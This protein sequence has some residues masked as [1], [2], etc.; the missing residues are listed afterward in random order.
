MLRLI[1]LALALATLAGCPEETAPTPPPAATP[2]PPP[3]PPA[4]ESIPDAGNAL[5][6]GPA[7]R[8]PDVGFCS[9]EHWCW[10]HPL[11]QGNTLYAVWGLSPED[12]WAAGARGTLLHFN[13]T[14]WAM[15]PSGTSEALTAIWGSAA[16]DLWALGSGVLLHYDGKKWSPAST[17]IGRRSNVMWGTGA[18]DVWVATSGKLQRWNGLRWEPQPGFDEL[19]LL[20]LKGT[21][22]QDVWALAFQP[23]QA[24]LSGLVVMHWNG[25]RW[26]RE[27]LPLA[28]MS[29]RLLALGPDDVWIAAEG[30]HLFHFDGKAWKRAAPPLP[31]LSAIAGIKGH[32]VFLASSTGKIA[33]WEVGSWAELPSP[34]PRAI[35]D[36]WAAAEDDIWAVGEGGAMARWNGRAWTSLAPL[37]GRDLE[38]VSGSSLDEV[39]AV[40]DG[41]VLR[42][43]EGVWSQG[44]AVPGEPEL[45]SVAVE[46]PERVWAVGDGALYR[47][48]DGAWKRE[49]AVPGSYRAVCRIQS[50]VWA[51]GTEG[52]AARWDGSKFLRMETGTAIDLTS[53]A[54]T[55]PR[56]LWA[57]LRGKKELLHFDGAGFEKIGG[58]GEAPPSRVVAG[59]GGVYA[60]GLA[61]VWRFNGSGWTQVLGSNGEAHGWGSAPDDVWGFEQGAIR[62]WNGVRSATS[63]SLAEDGLNAAWGMD[64]EVWAVG[65]RAAILHYR[66]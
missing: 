20:D 6:R 56:D 58:P 21:S 10:E 8:T 28:V 65:R 36:M 57:T 31:Q 27:V 12:V 30:R 52:L 42:R 26:A 33:R 7:P 14:G 39:W 19:S 23:R 44:P 5:V 47:L 54:A 18:S 3:P 51:V 59:P 53:V 24:P 37:S 25:S 46:G 66:P 50:E 61:G 29:A 40:G 2:I 48:E 60:A 32:G 35:L 41:V 4:A 22:A 1:L 63:P 17:K 62:H 43:R 34:G 38:A 11:P 45:T 55:S 64:G 15:V 49:Q 13:G 9:P 16:T